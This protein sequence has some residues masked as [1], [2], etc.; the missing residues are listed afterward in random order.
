[1]TIKELSTRPEMNGDKKLVK[2][3]GQLEEL[4]AEL[5]QR[6]LPDEVVK[7]I[8]ENVSAVNTASESGKA[9][10]KLLKKRTSQILRLLE[11]KLKLVPKNHYRNSWL[12]IGMAVFGVPLGTILGM[13]LENMA[14][15]GAGLPIGMLIGIAVG[16]G[17]DNKA[18]Q[19]GRQLN[20][21]IG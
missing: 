1:M 3:H 15:I 20:V 7:A 11:K 8:N 2:A 5:K 18:A 9:L 4:L 6:E 21:E 13:S 16:T 19:E 12:A 17:M 10:R 14:L